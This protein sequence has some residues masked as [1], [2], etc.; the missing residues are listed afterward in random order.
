ML[1]KLGVGYDIFAVC[2]F[3]KP[4]EGCEKQLD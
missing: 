3:Q 2:G 4:E 1:M